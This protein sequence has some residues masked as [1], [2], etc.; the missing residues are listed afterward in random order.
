MNARP[1]AVAVRV[2]PV[3]P[4]ETSMRVLQPEAAP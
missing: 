2:Q 3:Q 1:V 4:V